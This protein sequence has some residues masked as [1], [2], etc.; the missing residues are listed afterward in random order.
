M[1][2][3]ALSHFTNIVT[4]HSRLYLSFLAFH[5]RRDRGEPSRD[6]YGLNRPTMRGGRNVPDRE[7]DRN[8]GM[9]RD[10]PRGM[11]SRIK[12]TNT[13]GFKNKQFEDHR[14]KYVFC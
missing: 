4:L 8:N 14:R 6:R 12:P 10:R 13:P 9:G 11:D 3:C 2:A 5:G 1:V 7:R